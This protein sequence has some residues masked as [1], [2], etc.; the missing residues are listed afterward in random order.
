MIQFLAHQQIDKSRWDACIDHAQNGLI[1]GYSWYLDTMAPG[2]NALVAE[3]YSLVFPLPWNQKIPFFKQIYPPF[4]C[5]QLGAFY[6][7][8]SSKEQT[9]QLLASIPDTYKLVH[10]HLNASHSPVELPGWT[11]TTR[12]NLI[13]DL[14]PGYEAIVNGYN[15]STR[16]YS[17]RNRDRQFLVESPITPAELVQ[18]YKA[19]LGHKVECDDL[20]YQKFE[21]LMAL[22]IKKEKG[23]IMGVKDQEGTLTV[24]GFFFKSH[25]RIYNVFGASTPKGRQMRS[26]LFLLD[27]LIRKYAGLDMLFD[28]EGSS[29][30]SIAQFFEGF[31]AQ[32][33]IYYAVKKGT[34]PKWLLQLKSIYQ[35]L[36]NIKSGGKS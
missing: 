15:R 32:K 1:Y 36:P 19:Q 17:Q 13:L 29:I 20:T 33:E 3:D 4:F 21:Q 6:T 34:F 10:L 26:M 11:W 2:W 5:Q 27:G 23:S 24:A 12:N 25:G 8:A 7:E 14:K 30:P 16:R 22:A 35:K 31:G 9:S 18:L 28:F